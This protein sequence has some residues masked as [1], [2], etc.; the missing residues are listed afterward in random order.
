M[1]STKTSSVST[2]PNTTPTTRRAATSSFR[3]PA[4]TSRVPAYPSAPLTSREA[5]LLS[6]VERAYRI[7]GSELAARPS[8]RYGAAGE[9][10]SWSPSEE[11]RSFEPAMPVEFSAPVY[12]PRSALADAETER[13]YRNLA[14]EMM[15]RSALR[16]AMS[17]EPRS[18]TSPEEFRAFESAFANESPFAAYGTRPALADVEDEGENYRIRVELPGASKEELS[19]RVNDRTVDIRHTA[20]QDVEEREGERIPLL[21]ERSRGRFQRTLHLPESVLAEKT[22]ARF[23]DGVLELT[24]PKA[25]PAP[26]IA[27]R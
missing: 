15:A 6:E 25:N 10:R 16:F 1:Q 13:A 23:Q 3:A 14:S 24:L 21:A 22:E 9:P 8:P 2:P 12:A 11:P 27:I 5:Y 7:L 17:N 18:W 4:S 20:S 26:E 19:V